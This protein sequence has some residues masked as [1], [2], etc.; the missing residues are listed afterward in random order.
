MSASLAY[1]ADLVN[2]PFLRG[3][4]EMKQALGSIS[5][6]L[7]PVTE[8]LK[9]FGIGFG[10]FKSIGAVVEG[11]NKVLESGKE[12]GAISRETGESVATI[13]AL[14]KAYKE[15]GMDSGSLTANLAMLQNALGGVNEMGEPTKHIFDQL[16][17]SIE[18]LKGQSAVDQLHSIADA[19]SKLK[20]QSD[21]MAAVRGIFGR[22]GA[23]MLNLLNDPSVISD[24]QKKTS[25]S[26]AFREAHTTQFTEMVNSIEQAA[27][28][29]DQIFLGMT[30]A[31]VE[32]TKPFFDMLGKLDTLDV[33]QSIGQGL[34]LPLQIL[35]SIAII[36]TNVFQDLYNSG[37]LLIDALKAGFAA[38][39][40]TVGMLAPQIMQMIDGLK[41]GFLGLCEVIGGSLIEAFAK[42]IAYLKAGLKWA[43]DQAV[44]GL[45]NIPGLN[46][47]LHIEGHQAKSF[48]DY[49]KEDDGSATA[50]AGTDLK[51]KGREDLSQSVKS[52]Q[53]LDFSGVGDGIKA[54]LGEVWNGF[55]KD[56]STDIDAMEKG[57]K[58]TWEALVKTWNPEPIAEKK[59]EEKG[60]EGLKTS[61][62]AAKEK[63]SDNYSRIGL[64]VG[65]NNPAMSEAKKTNSLIGSLINATKEGN[66]RLVS[67]IADRL[68]D[69]VAV[70]N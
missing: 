47:L 56:A 68:I 59:K 51:A 18:K 14:R 35:S 15:V 52:F 42:P 17:L 19:V 65:G 48:D 25:K 32:A 3:V 4:R 7:G 10:A 6:G 12:L 16:G 9:G 69:R 8:A 30:P 5:E 38:V 67:A 49:L 13:V 26:G 22:A 62:V 43:F 21:K 50:K 24:A 45:S 28:K 2:S 31:V 63:I 57:N 41:S 70:W 54:A 60:E 58:N 11:I 27:A 55:K 53:T 40:V 66:N 36:L 33:G 20:T 23:P 37:A 46:K 64:F 29:I 1:K 61:Q 39:I 44:A 34:K